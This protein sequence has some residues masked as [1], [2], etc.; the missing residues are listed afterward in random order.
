MT[1]SA[2]RAESA[3]LPDA[4]RPLSAEDAAAAFAQIVDGGCGD[5]EIAAFLTA[6]AARGET[7]AEVAAAARVLRARALTIAAPAD[8]I[9]VCGTGGDGK[10]SLNISTAVAIVV[11]ACGVRVAKHGNRAASSRSGA[12]DVLAALGVDTG[13]AADRV[14]A[15][16][17]ELGIAFLF[18]ARHHSAMARVAPVRRALG[19]KTI[20][21]LLG[22]LANPAG[23]RRQLV[24]VYDARWVRPLAEVLRELGAERAMVVHGLDGIDEL[25][26]TGPSRAALL[27]DGRIVEFELAPEDAGLE[28]YPPEALAGGEPP[29]NAAALTALLG[30]ALGAYRDVVL[31][32]AAAALQVAGRAADLGHGAALAAAAIDSGAARALLQRW[33]QFR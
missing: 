21:N 7:V 24:G 3:A 1:A 23:V 4:S 29:E 19:I 28:R 13:M 8:A 16:L 6:M 26:V 32:N 27:A 9:D 2:A 12:A 20:F 22:P 33:S 31:L 17:A 15:C 18:A 5:A 25:T 10:H 11:A 30:G 14:E